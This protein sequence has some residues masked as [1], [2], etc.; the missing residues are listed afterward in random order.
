MDLMSFS[1][2]AFEGQ[3]S[4]MASVQSVLHV[5][6]LFYAIFNHPLDPSDSLACPLH[7]EL[8]DLS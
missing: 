8:V 7:S 4:L 3:K 1:Y 6:S 2:G 5:F